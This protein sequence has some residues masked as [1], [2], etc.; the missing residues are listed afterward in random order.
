[1]RV[2]PQSGVP[3]ASKPLT[4]S[5]L[6]DTLAFLA[7]TPAG[8]SDAQAAQ[9]VNH[10]GKNEPDAPRSGPWT[11]IVGLIA[12]PLMLLL[13]G[14]AI[15]A[16]AL[17]DHVGG[18][19]IA[20]MVVCGVGFNFV[21]GYRSQQA[22]ARLRETMTPMATLL[23][24]GRWQDRPR[25]DLVPG[26]V[27][28]LCAGDR[29]PADARL[30]EARDLHVQQAAL[31]GEAT[32]VE[33]SPEDLPAAVDAARA[34]HLVFLGTSVVAG[35]AT[36]VVY[37]T[38]RNTAF[39]DVAEALTQR[40]PPTEFERGLANFSRLI[41]RTIVVLLVFVVLAGAV[42]HRPAIETL[43]FALALV[44]GLTPEFMPVIT[45]VTL[46][47]AALT[48]SRQQVIVKHLSAIEDFGSMTVL[49]SDKTG[50]LTRGDT[51]VAEALDSWGA[52]ASHPLELAVLHSRHETGLRSPLDAAVLRCPLAVDTTWTKLDEIPFDFER[53]RSC[54]V[55]GR[56]EERLLVVKGAPEAV[57]AECV[58]AESNGVCAAFDAPSRSR[59]QATCDGLAAR[60]L[61]VL[62][63]AWR[64]AEAKASYAPSEE[65]GLT[66]AGFVSFV[67]PIA[68]AS[69]LP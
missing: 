53:R 16:A 58:Q 17:G 45:T 40:P 50:T 3:D 41:M 20:T 69:A 44:V 39:G 55:V 13:L 67:D 29:V 33:K 12:N 14:A 38:G 32:P 61:R 47:R 26:D 68:P 1:M 51:A 9:R 5:T 4:A 49:L 2:P 46:A 64:R 34:P 25:R 62:A 6:S 10:F 59:S 28:R 23:R 60:G 37:A 57:M 15:V 19:I 63:V 27:I 18:T 21:L 36:A 42:L 35:T 54:V 7:S 24:D 66:L 22:A 56:G 11:F 52:A 43:L 8:L 65:F 31:T 30:I 48:M